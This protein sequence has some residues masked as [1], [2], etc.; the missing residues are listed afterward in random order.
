MMI[1]CEIFKKIPKPWFPWPKTYS[2]DPTVPSTSVSE[3]ISF[4]NAVRE[5]GYHIFAHGGVLCDHYDTNTHEVYTLPA[6][7]YPMRP[8]LQISGEGKIISLPIIQGK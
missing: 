4:C 2:D 7:T 3:D 6:D 1:N 8:D 5:A